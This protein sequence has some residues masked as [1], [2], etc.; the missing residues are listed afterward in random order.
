[1]SLVNATLTWVK[2]NLRDEIDFVVWTGDSA[3][4]DSDEEI[5]R[6]NKDILSMNRRIS[7]AFF[8]TFS[9]DKGPVVPVVP[10]FGNNDIYP[11]NILLPGPN[12]ILRTY[13]N[14]WKEF[15][16]EA[17][18]HSF[19]FGG[20]FYVEVIPSKLAVF[21]LNTIYFFDRNAGVD[22]CV[23]PSEPGYK[24][25]EWLTVQLNQ[26]RSRGMKAIL[27][28]HVPPARTSGKQLW[29][30]SCWQKYT[31][32][33][34]QYRDII[35]GSLYGHMN[36]D[37]FLLQ[38]TRDIDITSKMS[39]RDGQTE[40]RETMSDDFS[41]LSSA[42]YLRELRDDWAK[43][44]D[45]VILDQ[46]LEHSKDSKGNKKGKHKL[47]GPHAERYQL[48]LIAPSIVP[49][50]FPSLRVFEYN[51]TGLEDS[52]TWV[53]HMRALPL[54]DDVL[55]PDETPEAGELKRR[56]SADFETDRKKKKKK[57]KGRKGKTPKDPNIRVPD[58]PAK[59]AL[60]GPAY[61]PQTLTLLGY[62]QYYANLTYINNDLV[63]NSMTDGHDSDGD[64]V[65][66]RGWNSGKHRGK[67][68]KHDKPR[69]KEFAFEVEYST[70]D[71]KIYKL[72]DLTVRSFVDL[73]HR[74]GQASAKSVPDAANDDQRVE[75]E[76]DKDD[77][78]VEEDQDGDLASQRAGK[79][80][81]NKNKNKKKKGHEVWLH[82]LKHAFVS[83]RSKEE[84]EKL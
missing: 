37:H 49:N 76:V 56:E 30:E 4:H 42:D 13:S 47:G 69:P 9:D 68:P 28:G 51:I 71:D 78:H 66:S 64:E 25:F 1:M 15:I 67:T 31:L 16:P 65:S 83:T 29:E 2:E 41:I 40:M 17:Q 61:Y 45:P 55:P 38:D 35:V 44:P 73:A 22:D 27:M 3:R 33:L 5:P 72:K 32:W 57:G 36:I 48:T 84:L 34:Q 81:K 60:P 74:I 77:E 19:E 39:S 54:D 18:R 52:P 20:W 79:K 14:I 80:N 82:F 59:D 63:D 8:D 43:L 7:D 62:T 11:H 10:T 50:Y 24:H 58:P 23:H 70:Y 12:D 21:S 75:S 46:D 6:H 53:D 26:L